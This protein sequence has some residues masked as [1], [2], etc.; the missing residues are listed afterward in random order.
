MDKGIMLKIKVDILDGEINIHVDKSGSINYISDDNKTN[1]IRKEVDPIY[2][3][4]YGDIIHLGEAYP[5]LYHGSI[6]GLAYV[7]STITTS[8]VCT[9]IGS[10]LCLKNEE[11]SIYM[12]KQFIDLYKEFII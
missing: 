8:S 9:D 5:W 11:L 12:G 10:R 6:L 2:V 7:S 3:P 4:Q 1:I